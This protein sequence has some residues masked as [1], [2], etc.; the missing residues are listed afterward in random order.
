MIHWSVTNCKDRYIVWMDGWVIAEN[1][2]FD[3]CYNLVMDL[4]KLREKV[5]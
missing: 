3:H 5:S 2:T 4:I 1:V